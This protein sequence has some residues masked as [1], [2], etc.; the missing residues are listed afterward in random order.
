MLLVAEARRPHQQL[1]Q[2]V[3]DPSH[4]VSFIGPVLNFYPQVL[5]LSV[6]ASQRHLF[7]INPFPNTEGY[8]PAP[9]SLPISSE[10]LIA[11]YST[12]PVV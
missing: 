8:T 7:A 10:K 11:L 2:P 3:V 1:R 9:P 5:N 6:A 12:V 4:K